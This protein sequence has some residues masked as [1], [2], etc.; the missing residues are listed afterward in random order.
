MVISKN[1]HKKL[2]KDYPA[3]EMTTSIADH[4]RNNMNLLPIEQQLMYA[5]LEELKEIKELLKK[6]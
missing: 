1:I 2:L 6:R 5:I 3:T 4:H